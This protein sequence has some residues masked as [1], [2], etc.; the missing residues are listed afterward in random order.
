MKVYHGNYLGLV[1][2]SSD[3]EY[4]GRVQVFIPHIMPALYD[5]WN[6]EGVDIQISCVGSNIPE[7]LSPEIHERLVK[8]LPWAESASP[9]IGGSAPGNLF[10]SILGGAAA[11][12][13]TG[14]VAGAL[15]GAAT[16]AANHFYNQSPTSNPAPGVTPTGNSVADS[17]IKAANE[18]W[19]SANQPGAGNLGCAAMVS[20]MFRSGTGQGIIGGTKDTVSTSELYS[21]LSRDTS[22]FVKIPIEQAGAGDIIVTSALY[23]GGAKKQS[24]HAGIC[25]GDGKIVSNSSSSASVKQNYTLDSWNRTIAKRNPAQTHAFRYIGDSTGQPA[26]PAPSSS[27]QESTGGSGAPA[28]ASPQTNKEGIVGP[29]PTPQQGAI[30]P[31]EGA[32]QVAGTVSGGGTVDTTNMSPAFKAQYERVYAGLEG[33]KFI[34]TV[35]KDGSTY[36]IKTGS[37]EEWAHFFTRNA[38]VE[39]G[40]NPNTAADINGLRKG[41]LTSFGLYQ[42]GSTQFNRHGGGNIYNPDDNTKSFLNYA[43]SLY[44][45][46]TYKSGGQNVIGGKTESGQWLGLAAGYGPIRRIT[47]GKPS[48]HQKQ[49]LA[50]N[51]SAA[52]KQTGSYTGQ[53]S[54][55]G[56]TTTPTSVVNNT[57]SNGRTPV[58]NTNDMAKGMFAYPNPGAMVWVFFREG[59]PLYPVYFAASYSSAEWQSAYRGSSPGDLRNHGDTKNPNAEKNPNFFTSATNFNAEGGGL[60]FKSHINLANPLEN[61]C[62]AAFNHEQ[63]SGVTMT[64]GCDFYRSSSNRRDEVDNDRHIVTRGYKEEW[65]QGDASTNTRGDVFIK[66][67]NITQ[68]AIDAMTELSNMSYEANQKLMEKP[69]STAAAPA[70]TATSETPSAANNDQAEIDKYTKA[71]NEARLLSIRGDQSWDQ[72]VAWQKQADEF[73]RK[74]EELLAKQKK[75]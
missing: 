62:V 38:S 71:E 26:P 44:F 65:V 68:E 52:E 17:A 35:P 27:G 64:N 47:E 70:N 61:Q 20:K 22:R 30:V 7:G 33:S 28:P 58:F 3:P 4:R 31:T 10:S 25:I 1:I 8:I 14:G 34:N 39:S 67:G 73:A 37:R 75:S 46:N 29:A 69:K 15:V 66:V 48:T 19:S 12:A 50:E 60:L 2:N 74:K 42:M 41:P 5:D 9:I 13:A 59:N 18:G 16:G 72:K 51:M 57:D 40:F 24:G 55:S 49:L 56:L 32:G 23:Q 6:K 45:G 43:E 63:G 36:G 53:V 21:S 11:G 54:P